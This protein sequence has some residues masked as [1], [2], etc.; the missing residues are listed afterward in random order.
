MTRQIERDHAPH[1]LLGHGKSP[2]PTLASGLFGNLSIYDN[3]GVLIQVIDALRARGLAPRV[4]LGHSMGGLA[5]QGAQEKLLAAGSSLAKHGVFSAIL[6]APVPVAEITAWKPASTDPLPPQYYRDDN[7]VYIVLDAQAALFSGG[8]ST[9]ASTPGNPVI[10]P[11]AFT[12]DFTG[13]IGAEP[14]VTIGQLVGVIPNLP[15]PSAR[16]GAFSLRNGTLLS[17]VG[18]SE[19]ILTPAALQPALYEHLLG[20]QGLLY[21][22]VVAPDAVHSM[23]LINPNELLDQLCDL[24]LMF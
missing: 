12:L 2:I 7:G 5:I 17:V 4:V 8:F 13:Q 20:R 6:M 18:F 10:T 1:Q 14:Q 22:E 3:V 24:E 11:A 15:R 19:D 16:R 9:T 23:M 21:Q